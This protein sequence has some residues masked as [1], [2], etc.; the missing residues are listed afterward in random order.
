MQLCDRGKEW[1]H[2]EIPVVLLAVSFCFFSS[3]ALYN[4]ITPYSSYTQ[5]ARVYVHC[6]ATARNTVTC[7]GM[8]RCAAVGEQ[9]DRGPCS[10]ELPS[11][12]LARPA[13]FDTSSPCIQ[14]ACCS[15]SFCNTKTTNTSPFDAGRPRTGEQRIRGHPMQLHSRQYAEKCMA[16]DVAPETWRSPLVAPSHLR[17]L[18]QTARG[19][20]CKPKA[21]AVNSW[22]LSIKI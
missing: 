19:E 3:V 2:G 10:A 4:I 1:W 22:N 5:L 15:D 8:P 20:L 7:C 14:L 17:P 16:R 6:T 21:M 12:L 11:P 13:T 9:V 18:R